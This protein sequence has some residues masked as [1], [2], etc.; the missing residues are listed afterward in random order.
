[1]APQRHLLQ[2]W[3]ESKLTAIKLR[4]KKNLTIDHLTRS[5]CNWKSVKTR[6]NKQTDKWAKKMKNL[7]LVFNW[8]INT[9]YKL[10]FS[11]INLLI[12]LVSLSLVRTFLL[13]PRI[14]FSLIYFLS[15][16]AFSVLVQ[17]QWKS[18]FEYNFT[19]FHRCEKSARNAFKWLFFFSCNERKKKNRFLLLKL[20]ES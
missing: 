20:C 4:E 9:Q 10:Q 3:P 16:F 13:P 11:N 12:A 15:S 14:D 18:I 5:K 7:K 1:M 8:S 19:R 17:K 6:T 2:F